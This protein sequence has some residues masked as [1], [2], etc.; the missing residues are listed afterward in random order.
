MCNTRRTSK[1]PESCCNLPT[2]V[3]EKWGGGRYVVLVHHI[4]TESMPKLFKKFSAR[5]ATSV[6]D[7]S[8]EIHF[9]CTIT[10][11]M[12]WCKRFARSALHTKKEGVIIFAFVRGKKFSTFPACLRTQHWN[13]GSFRASCVRIPTAIFFFPSVISNCFAYCNFVIVSNIYRSFCVIAFFHVSYFRGAL[14]A[15]LGTQFVNKFFAIN[16]KISFL[17]TKFV[18]LLVIYNVF[19]VSV[20]SIIFKK[21]CSDGILTIFTTSFSI[22]LSIHNNAER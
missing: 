20:S 13:S 22:A 10:C 18:S 6:G 11:T 9:F 5:C 8:S 19:A 4:Q 21:Y 12:R 15:C 2:L 7:A 3:L 16:G 1:S 14:P 17:L